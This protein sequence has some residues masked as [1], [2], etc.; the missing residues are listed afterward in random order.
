MSYIVREVSEADKA[1]ILKFSQQ[2]P[3]QPAY[4]ASLVRRFLYELAST[5]KLVFDLHDK[6]GRVACGVLIDKV[7]NPAN[8]ACLEVVGMRKGSD[9]HQV[10]RQLIELCKERCPKHRA[11]FQF[12]AAEQSVID[13]EF[14][15]QMGCY[16]N[17]STYEMENRTVAARPIEH[18]TR[19]VPSTKAASPDVYKVLC[20]A[21]SKNP[22]TSIPESETWHENFMRSNRSHYYLWNDKNQ[23]VAFAN[24]VEPD[25]GDTTEV[26][27]IG[28]LPSHRGSGIGRELLQHCLNET[29]RLGYGKCHLT[30]AVEN[31]KALALYLRSGFEVLEKYKCYRMDLK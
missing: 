13:D 12:G 15:R 29:V 16:N 3:W 7:N 6:S 21:F 2:H 22:D 10:L 4:P 5:D 26:R 31:E 23:L 14:A 20:E 27:T 8:D 9:E 11:G 17:Y 18:T 24:L 19:I 28:V 30:V 1:D 25:S